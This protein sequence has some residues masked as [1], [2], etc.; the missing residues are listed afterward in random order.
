MIPVFDDSPIIG[1]LPPPPKPD[2]A[3][4]LSEDEAESQ[5]RDLKAIADTTRLRIISLLMRHGGEVCVNDIVA[6]FNLEQATISHHLRILRDAGLIGARKRA[7]WSYYFVKHERLRV[8][9]QALTSL[10]HTDVT[11]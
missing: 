6:Y 10:I 5:A 2:A 9:L 1:D 4:G 7:L 8:I 11:P 3:P